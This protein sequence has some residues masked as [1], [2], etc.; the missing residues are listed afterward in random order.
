M[1]SMLDYSGAA[2]PSH[3]EWVKAMTNTC[4]TTMSFHFHNTLRKEFFA[5]YQYLQVQLPL[6]KLMDH[7]LLQDSS[8]TCS[9]NLLSTLNS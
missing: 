7:R 9:Q 6:G 8:K 4:R 2:Q 5:S 3:E 1:P